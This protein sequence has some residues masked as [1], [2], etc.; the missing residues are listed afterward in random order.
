MPSRTIRGDY[1][2]DDNKLVGSSMNN[3]SSNQGQGRKTKAPKAIKT[4]KGQSFVS[5]YTYENVYEEITVYD[6]DEE[7]DDDH[8]RESEDDR[9]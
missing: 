8:E 3:D 6:E 4:M 9:R 1:D 2:D 7:E 5:E